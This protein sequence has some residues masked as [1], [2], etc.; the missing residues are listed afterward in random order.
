MKIQVVEHLYRWTNWEI[1]NNSDA[2]TQRDART[3]EF[4]VQLLP[5]GEK[6]ITYTAH[7]SW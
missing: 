3:V 6:V 5:E 7:Y 2:F 4:P 1:V